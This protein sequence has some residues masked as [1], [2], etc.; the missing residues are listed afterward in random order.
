MFRTVTVLSALRYFVHAVIPSQVSELRTNRPKKGSKIPTQ[1]LYVAVNLL[2]LQRRKDNKH[3]YEY[4]PVENDM[5]NLCFGST[6][7]RLDCRNKSGRVLLCSIHTDTESFSPQ[8]TVLRP[9]PHPAV[10]PGWLALACCLL[11]QIF[12]CDP[13]VIESICYRTRAK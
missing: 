10:R 1:L 2:S 3:T 4:I 6:L 12:F 5:N 11:D 9:R 7:I 8:C 13:V